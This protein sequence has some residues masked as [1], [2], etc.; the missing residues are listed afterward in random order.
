MRHGQVLEQ[1]FGA[2]VHVE[3]AQLQIEHRLA[4]H[5]EQ[6]VPGLDDARVHRA[7][8]HLENAFAFHLAELVPLALNGGSTVRRSKS[9]RNG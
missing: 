4:G 6:E 9:L 3:H 2:L 7:D 1:F 8:R 5:A